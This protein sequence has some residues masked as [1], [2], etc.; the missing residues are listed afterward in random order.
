MYIF[1]SVCFCTCFIENASSEAFCSFVYTYIYICCLIVMHLNHQQ[2]DIPLCWLCLP[3]VT[4][5]IS[6]Y[7][8]PKK[9][10][11]QKCAK[12]IFQRR[13]VFS[14]FPSSRWWAAHHLLVRMQANGVKYNVINNV[15]YNNFI[16][17]Y[18]IITQSTWHQQIEAETKW[19]PFCRR[20]FQ[21]YFF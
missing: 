10:M 16:L 18:G 8:L 1:Y 9:S 4:K 3:F 15:T 19:P 12:L 11:W 5:T 6:M 2:T 13:W 7:R 21:I 14:S 20:H 17:C